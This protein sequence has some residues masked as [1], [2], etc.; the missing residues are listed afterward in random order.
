MNY[1]L[2]AVIALLSYSLVPP[3]SKLASEDMP[4]MVV[5]FV[6]NAMI[7]IANLGVILYME[8]NLMATVSSSGIV[9]AVG[10]GVFLSVGILSYFYSL[11]TGPVSVVTPIFGMFLVASSL[12]GILALGEAATARKLAGLALAGIAVY[13]AAGA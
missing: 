1:L 5:A 9:Y 8:D 3:L 10:A 12:V 2:F 7:A 11:S 6:A 4:I 13:L